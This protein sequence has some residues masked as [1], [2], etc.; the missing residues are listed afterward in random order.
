MIDL[1]K[2]KLKK[3]NVKIIEDRIVDGF[4]EL[5]VDKIPGQKIAKRGCMRTELY[6]FDPF[7]I[8]NEDAGKLSDPKS[9]I[10]ELRQEVKVCL[11]F[12]DD[13]ILLVDKVAIIHLNKF[14]SIMFLVERKI[15][16]FDE[17]RWKDRGLYDKACE[18]LKRAKSRFPDI[19]DFELK[20][21]G[22]DRKDGKLKFFDVFPKK[23]A[24]I[25][26]K[27]N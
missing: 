20:D 4:P 12:K 16:P 14:E 6:D 19:G 18:L 23:G 25:S 7:F 3:A 24:E 27:H 26:S 15:E 10:E 17:T 13:E 5:V 22:Y 21:I 8:K 11:N 1:F 9:S 2:I